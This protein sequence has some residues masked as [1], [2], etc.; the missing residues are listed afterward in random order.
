VQQYRLRPW[1]LSFFFHAAIAASFVLLSL[2]P[3]SIK[4]F[5]PVPL[6]FKLPAE[7]QNLSEVQ[8]KPKV[9]LKSVNEAPPTQKEARQVFGASRRSHTDES[10]AAGVDAKLGNTLA[11]EVDQLELAD[12][13]P[14]ALPTPTEEYL[15]S[16]MPVVL[17]EVRPQYPKEARERQLEGAVVMDILIDEQGVVREAKVIE[18]PTEFQAVAVEAMRKF[19]FRP[20]RVDGNPVAVMIRYT[21]R[22]QLEF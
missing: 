18:G 21:L 14:D 1:Q 22:F 19:K 2:R 5:T 20:A 10:Q 17:T 8:E 13:D 11:K 16:E 4:E 3:S 9:T 7:A 12:A 6:E 15:V